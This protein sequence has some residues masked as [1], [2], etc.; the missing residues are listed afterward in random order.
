MKIKGI[1]RA[2]EFI[3]TIFETDEEMRKAYESLDEDAVK[4]LEW[5]IFN[6]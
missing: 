2:E 3:C 1:D 4:A 6:K 5:I